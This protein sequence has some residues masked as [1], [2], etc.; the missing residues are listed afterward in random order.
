MALPLPFVAEIKIRPRKIRTEKSE[1]K[2]H[3]KEPRV[4]APDPRWDPKKML[5][6]P[7]SRAQKE[8]CVL[9]VQH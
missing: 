7:F 8:A 3:S 5:I 1:S 9:N 2:Q 4:V 6:K